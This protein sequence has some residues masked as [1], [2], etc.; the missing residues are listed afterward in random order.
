MQALKCI[1]VI[2]IGR[3]VQEKSFQLNI[4]FNSLCPPPSLSSSLLAVQLSSKTNQPKT[5]G[6]IFTTLWVN[7]PC[8]AQPADP[9]YWG[10]P[11]NWQWVGLLTHRACGRQLTPPP[12]PLYHIHIPLTASTYIPQS[13]PPYLSHL[14]AVHTILQSH[15]TLGWSEKHK[16]LKMQKYRA[17]SEPRHSID[18]RTIFGIMIGWF[19]LREIG[20][21]Y[22]TESG[23]NFGTL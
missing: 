12:R 10:W 14:G 13:W 9:W 2:R 16:S 15:Y 8:N 18:F 1:K 21:M 3:L 23:G 4:T 5:N 11:A 17:D 22:F 20:Q 6:N 19:V 7:P